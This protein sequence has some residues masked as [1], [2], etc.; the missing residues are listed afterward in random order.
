MSREKYMLKE[1]DCR[2]NTP[3]NGGKAKIKKGEHPLSYNGSRYCVKRHGGATLRD[4]RFLDRRIY[5]QFRPPTRYS[6]VR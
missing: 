5:D 4:K 6:R 1:I 2:A 3:K